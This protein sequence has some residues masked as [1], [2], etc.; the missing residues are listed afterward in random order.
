MSRRESNARVCGNGLLDCCF[1]AI[2]NVNG[3]P[4]SNLN[5]AAM[6]NGLCF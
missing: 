4:L 6:E 5:L 2:G 3:V 1:S